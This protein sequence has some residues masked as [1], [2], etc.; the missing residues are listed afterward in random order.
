MN[1]LTPGGG[2]PVAVPVAWSNH[3][4]SDLLSGQIAPP[5]VGDWFTPSFA[6]QPHSIGVPR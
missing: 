5:S 4:A 1:G 6:H 2:V 3:R